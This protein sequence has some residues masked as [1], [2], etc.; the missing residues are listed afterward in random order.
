MD[1]TKTMPEL[2]KFICIGVQKGGTTTLHNLLRHHPEISMSSRKELQY[3]TFNYHLGTDWYLSQWPNDN[4]VKLRGETTPYYIFHPYAAQRMKELIPEIKILILLR[5][6]VERTISHYH[7]AV[8][9]GFETLSFYDALEIEAQRLA[10]AEETLLD[11]SSQHKCHQENSY[12]SRSR[13]ERQIPAWL[14][15]FPSNQVL[16]LRSE[17]LFSNPYRLWS[18][19]SRHLDIREIAFPKDKFRRLNSGG[20]TGR[21]ITKEQREFIYQRLA[22]TYDFL[23]RLVIS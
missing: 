5:D 10:G 14:N 11:P 6:P 9:L 2:P 20:A 1:S 22:T 8:R 13:Y 23:N 21:S 4:T 15:L 12:L 16:I 7:H 17:E 18:K 3:F 19:V